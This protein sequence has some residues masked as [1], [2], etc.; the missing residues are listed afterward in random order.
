[1][2]VVATKPLSSEHLTFSASFMLLA[3]FI[4]FLLFIS[5]PDGR[6]AAERTRQFSFSRCF[7]FSLLLYYFALLLCFITV[8]AA[9]S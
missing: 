8:S 7:L 1:M 6:S 2:H 3:F 5:P 9:K 4:L